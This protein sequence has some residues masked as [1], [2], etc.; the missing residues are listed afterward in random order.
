[1]S[2]GEE[3]VDWDGWRASV[4][5]R[6]EVIWSGMPLAGRASWRAS[7]KLSETMVRAG[8]GPPWEA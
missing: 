6:V 7:Q 5:G 3:P 8:E 4:N 2:M 1:M